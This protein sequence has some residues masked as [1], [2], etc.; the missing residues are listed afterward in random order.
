MGGTIG[1]LVNP[2][3]NFNRVKNLV[4]KPSVKNW[5][6]ATTGG[7]SDIVASQPGIIGQLGRFGNWDFSKADGGDGPETPDYLVDPRQM[8]EDQ[9]A[10]NDLGKSQYDETI[11]GIDTNSAAQEKYAQ[12]VFQRMLPQTAEDYNAG[13][14]LNSTGYQQE[15]S[16][17]AYDLA[18]RV[19][20]ESANAKFSALGAKQGFGTSA[21]Q[22]GLSLEDFNNQAELAKSLGSKD[23]PNS[24]TGGKGGLM[25]GAAQG[26]SMGSAAGPWGALIGGVGGAFM[27]S[28]NNAERKQLG[29]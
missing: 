23:L 12:D 11:A 10:I 29:K 4:T 16:R 28:R 27:G 21:M 14:L 25:G 7:Q 18:S 9:K 20:A 13:G 6:S 22:R 26:A 1:K 19:A 2:V 24:P 17:Q 3:D 5:H 15:A 8:Y